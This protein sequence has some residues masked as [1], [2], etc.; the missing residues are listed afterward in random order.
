[1]VK[2]A[3]L[4]IHSSTDDRGSIEGPIA[5]GQTKDAW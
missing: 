3:G 5:Y 4:N 2:T 1:M